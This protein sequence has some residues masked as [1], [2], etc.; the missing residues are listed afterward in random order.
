MKRVRRNVIEISQAQCDALAELSAGL[1][2][3]KRVTVQ[4]TYTDTGGTHLYVELPYDDGL[5]FISYD[6]KITKLAR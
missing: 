3:H 4:Q 5:V 6:G 2:P 1:L